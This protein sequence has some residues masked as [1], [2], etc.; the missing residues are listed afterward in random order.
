MLPVTDLFERWDWAIDA[1]RNYLNSTFPRSTTLTLC[2]ITF[3]TMAELMRLH[4]ARYP[5]EVLQAGSSDIG[6]RI[7]KIMFSIP[8]LGVI[9]IRVIEIFTVSQSIVLTVCLVVISM[10]PGEILPAVISELG[11]GNDMEPAP[12]PEQTGLYESRFTSTQTRLRSILDTMGPAVG[13]SAVLD[14]FIK[15]VCTVIT[16]VVTPVVVLG[17]IYQTEGLETCM[18]E[19]FGNQSKTNWA[20]RAVKIIVRESD[21]MVAPHFGT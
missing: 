2:A 5:P 13:D 11:E 14:L 3:L 19:V 20:H 17:Q 15:S 7:L 12:L 1:Y 6:Y 4:Y 8:V 9:A 10:I 21:Q 18:R 16:L